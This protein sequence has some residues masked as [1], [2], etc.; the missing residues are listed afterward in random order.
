MMTNCPN[1][2]HPFENGKCKYCGTEKQIRMKSMM[3]ISKDGIE[4]VCY[5][6]DEEG[7]QYV[8]I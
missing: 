4:L 1:C 2:G 6:E 5:S 7:E 3:K 8:S